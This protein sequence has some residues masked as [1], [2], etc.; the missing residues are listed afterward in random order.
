MHDAGV[1]WDDPEPLERLLRPPQQRIPLAVALELEI[2]IGLE[3]GRR[4]ELVDD[5]GVIDHELGRKQRVYMLRVAAHCPDRVAHGGEIDD[6]GHARKVLEQHPGRHERDLFIRC[7]AGIPAGQ[8][9]HVGGSHRASVLPAQ[10][11]FEQDLERVGQAG[12]REPT[13]LEGVEAED[14]EGPATYRE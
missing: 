6:R 11:I 14:L 1:G 9:F 13:A 8:P 3:G 7:L 10:Q 12:D 2:G 4:A 5:H